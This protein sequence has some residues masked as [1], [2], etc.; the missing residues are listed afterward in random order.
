MDSLHITKE[1]LCVVPLKGK[2]GFTFW[3]GCLETSR[4][5][6]HLVESDC[7]VGYIPSLIIIMYSECCEPGAQ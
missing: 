2:L 6:C 3:S 7:T 5:Q 4:G 1:N